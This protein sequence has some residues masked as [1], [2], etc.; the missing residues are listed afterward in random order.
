MAI[1]K[2]FIKAGDILA[3]KSVK[4]SGII[5]KL[6]GVIQVLIGE[7]GS[8]HRTYGHIAIAE[9]QEYELEMTWPKSRRHKINY[10]SPEV[11]LWRIKKAEEIVNTQDL[12]NKVQHWFGN[13]NVVTTRAVVAVTACNRRLGELY[14]LVPLLT[15]GIIG[16][17]KGCSEW[18]AEAWRD[19]GIVL[20]AEG[21]TDKLVSPNEII[22]SQ[23]I[24]K[25]TEVSA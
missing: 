8:Y 13:Q 5:G 3:Y 20:S 1:K 2:E 9:N 7:G 19:A 14:D 11:E 15:F 21:P 18:V 22:S 10:D 16:S 23:E 17:T 25:V 12:N 24:F 4:E 6:I